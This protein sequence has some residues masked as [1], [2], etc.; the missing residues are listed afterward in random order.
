M[1]TQGFCGQSLAM[2]TADKS[3]LKISCGQGGT[4]QCPPKGSSYIVCATLAAD[5]VQVDNFL[6]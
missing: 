6:G 2:A 4:G 1:S 5:N 3:K